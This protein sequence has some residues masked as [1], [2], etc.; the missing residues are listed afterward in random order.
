MNEHPELLRRTA[1]L[2]I[3]FL[4]SLPDRQVAGQQD[5][6]ELRRE[7][8]RTLTEEGEDGQVV[9]E[10]LARIGGEA[11]VA[12]AGPRY[13]GFVIGGSLPSALA[14]DWLTSTWDQNAGLYVAGPAASVVEEAVGSWLIDLFGLPPTAS[15]GLVTGCQM[16]HFTCLAAARQAVLERAE[17]DV[18]GRGLFGA[19]EIE[20]IVGDEA[21][22]TVLTALQ[23]LG[24]GRDRV[25]IV[26]ADDQG[27]LSAAALADALKAVPR[28]APL[29]V[30]LQAGNVN[31][32]SFDPIRE[33][34]GLVR[35]RPGAWVHVDGAFGL[36]AAVSPALAHLVDGIGLADSW[37]TDAHKWLNVPYDSGLAFVADPSAHA[38]A[39]AP[40][41]AAYLEYG[42]EQERDEVSWVPEFSRRARGFPIYAALRTLGRSG[43]RRLVERCCA[44]ARRMAERLEGN[45]GVKILNEVVLNQVLVR[46]TP[47]EGGDADAFTREIIRRVQEDG[48]IWLSGTTWHGMAAM[49]ISVSNWSTTEADA[50]VAVDAILR[51]LS[52][53]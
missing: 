4:D 14:A 7:L 38:A 37:A 15:Y 27:R 45:P 47:P 44:I 40:P 21:H 5:V 39:M 1:E 26:E 28:D 12:M 35:D 51:C 9:V 20:V 22:S 13:F 25:R 48:T 6:H 31:T 34:I 11:A 3:E 49:R 23:Y 42:P 19:P 36:W 2:A 24:L 33:S 53:R 16:A 46:F 41:H 18:T 30:C 50:D 43:V 52:S 17:W 8:V 32:G 29:I 10:D